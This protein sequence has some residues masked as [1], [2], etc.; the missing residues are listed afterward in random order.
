PGAVG[1]HGGARGLSAAGAW[2]RGLEELWRV[3]LTDPGRDDQVAIAR[4]GRLIT[5]APLDVLDA[6][7]GERLAIGAHTLAHRMARDIADFVRDAAR[8]SIVMRALGKSTAIEFDP[9]WLAGFGP[10]T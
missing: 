2:R 5:G 10:E 7:L 3:E 6:A 4:C 1:G 8:S 9:Q